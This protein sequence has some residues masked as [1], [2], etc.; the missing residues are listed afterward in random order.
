MKIINVY[1]YLELGSY[2]S[3]K[4]K[5]GPRGLQA[6]L[7]R[8]ASCQAIHLINVIR[9]NAHLSE[10]Q[11]FK[12][13]S[14]LGLNEPEIEY[15]LDLTRL[16]R[17]SAPETKLF[18]RKSLSSKVQEQTDLR[19]RVSGKA[20]SATVEDQSYYF[21]TPLVSLI[22]L[23]T[24]CKKLQTSESIS[25]WLKLEKNEVDAILSFLEEKKLVN[26]ANGKFEYSGNGIHLSKQSP[27]HLIFQKIRREFVIRQIEKKRNMEIDVNFS[28]AFAT[29]QAHL[30]KIK[31]GLLTYI[32]EMHKELKSTDSEDLAVLVIDLCKLT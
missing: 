16:D 27:L 2:L 22:H 10:D 5:F 1:D 8:A 7:A 12:I 20:M 6:R 32:D 24:S 25:R 26:G 14:S 9:G 28:S 4:L 19:K 15:L 3:D 18:L 21:C 13:G 30:A 11:A 17:A 23:A 31:L 29:S